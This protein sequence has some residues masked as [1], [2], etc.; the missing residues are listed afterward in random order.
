MQ[1]LKFLNYNVVYFNQLKLFTIN[2]IFE[3]IKTISGLASNL[4]F[5][6]FRF[7]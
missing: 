2:D 5:F 4:I 7:E 6:F 3:T 1:E